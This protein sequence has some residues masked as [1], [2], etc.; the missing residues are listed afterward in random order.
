MQTCKEIGEFG[1]IQKLFKNIPARRSD[2]I[3]GTGDDAAAVIAEPGVLLLSTVDSQVEGV[4]FRW[5]LISA[6]QLGHK[7]AAINLSDIR[8][9]ERR[10]GKECRARGSP[11]H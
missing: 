9:E 2:V 5:E 3:L 11:Y 10:V 1:L 6:A 7:L 4:H 8:S